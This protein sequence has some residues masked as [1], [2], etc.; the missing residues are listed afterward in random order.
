MV[1]FKGDAIELL[2]QQLEVGAQAPDF[3]LVDQSLNR[4]GLNAFEGK[5]KV[6]HCAP[7]FETPVCVKAFSQL[8]E[9]FKDLKEIAVLHISKDLPFAQKRFCDSLKEQATTLS[10]FDS[11][12][13]HD[14]GLYIANGPL[15]GLLG[16]CIFLLDAQN[17]IVYKDLVFEITQ[18]PNYGALMEALG[19]IS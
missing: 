3:E 11:S 2:N 10:A 13:A 4:F 15:K 14:Y 16:R 17:K 8:Q 12:F 18:E 1:V 9:R 19:Q 5:I 6:L 7:S